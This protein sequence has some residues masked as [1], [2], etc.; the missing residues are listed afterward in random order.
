M[1]RAKTVSDLTV[2]SLGQARPVHSFGGDGWPMSSQ[3]HIRL[4]HIRRVEIEPPSLCPKPRVTG[5]DCFPF[6]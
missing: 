5:V 1:E 6:V 2:L 3:R 4:P